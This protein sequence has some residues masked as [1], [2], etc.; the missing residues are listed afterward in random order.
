MY[1]EVVPINKSDIIKIK[2]KG[3]I[4]E[5]AVKMKNIPQKKL[6]NKLLEENKINVKI[7]DQ[8]ADFKIDHLIFSGGEP[9][10]RRD[11]FDII[12]HA[13]DRGIKMID[14]ITNGL[15][16]DKSVAQRLVKSRLTHITISI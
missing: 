5:Y 9:L 8:I 15:L 13:A 1:L 10:L 6:M 3:K 2:G 12:A 4:V 11:I 16:I 14:L 7:I